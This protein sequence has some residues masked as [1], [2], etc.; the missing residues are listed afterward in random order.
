[1][2]LLTSTEIAQRHHHR[3]VRFFWAWLAG[4]TAVSLVGNVAHAALTA[5]ESTRWLAAAVAAV[6][7]TVLLASV[8]G[9]A[10]LAKTSASGRVYRAAVAATT[11]LALGAFLLSFVALRDLAM[12]AHIPAPLA[13][14]LPLVIDLAIGVATLALVAVGDKPTRRAT[15]R[16]AQPQVSN[17][18]APTPAPRPTTPTATSTAPVAPRP[19]ST[20]APNTTRTA[21]TTAPQ[22]G[23]DAPA[24]APE[25][26]A[27]AERIVS[28]GSTRQDVRVV[29]RILTLAESEPRKAVIE[30]QLGVHHSVIT[31]VL[32]AAERERRSQLQAVS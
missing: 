20:G 22:N 6:P 27:L 8:H 21:P 24:P 2:S 30:R 32:E 17:H 23:A 4:A 13:F 19:P 25:L 3:A 16:A 15:Q 14:V 12:L 11:A 18:R 7:P 10:V 9:I 31:K 1:M 5:S 26:I 29:A 28:N